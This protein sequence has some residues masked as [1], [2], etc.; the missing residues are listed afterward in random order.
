MDLELVTV[1]TE[2]LL[3]HTVDTNAA[4]VARTLAAAGVR[5][6]RGTTV[7]DDRAAIEEAVRDGLAR[8]GLVLTTGGLGPTSDDLTREAVAAVYGVPLDIDEG[9]L[10][11]LRRRFAAL[12]RGP[13]PESNRSQAAVPRGGVMLPN[14]RGTAPGLWVTDERGSVILLPGVPREMQGLLEREVVPR[15]R[16]RLGPGAR[17][18]RSR[19]LRTTGVAESALADR[20]GPHEAELTPARLA[21]VPG[22]EGVDLR[23]SVWHVGAAEAD[24]ALARAAER[25]ES[26]VGEHLYGEDDADLAAVVLEGLRRQGARLAVAESCTGGLIGARLTAVPG[27]SEVFLG[28]VV[29]YSDASKIGA[30]GVDPSLLRSQGAVSEAVAAAMALGVRDRFEADA[31]VAVTGIAGPGGGTADKPVGTVW[32]SALVGDR[33]RTVRRWLPG[34]RAEVRARSAQAG[35]DLLRR[36]GAGG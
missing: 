2:L 22:L 29:C 32:I 24:A 34:G 17:V 6:V 15:L 33:R 4:V 3:G 27:A 16:E 35:L 19:T 1:G 8:T 23:L 9:Y 18:V 14:P 10:E 36:L 26:I 21:Y 28:G 11:Q 12:G 13:M 30:V 5:V 20:L 31:A 25:I 7:G